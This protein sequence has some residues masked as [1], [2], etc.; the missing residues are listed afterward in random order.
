MPRSQA[1]WI[2]SAAVFSLYLAMGQNAFHGLDAFSYLK[3]VHNGELHNQLNLLY[4]P[5]AWVFARLCGFFGL[6]LYESLRLLSAIGGAL[7]AAFTHRTALALGIDPTRALLSAFGCG[8]TPAV[9]HSSTVVE[10]DA[11]FFACSA[12]AWLPFAHLLRTGRWSFAML[13]GAASALAAGCHAAGH[14]LVLTLCLMQIAWDWPARSL[15]TT[16]PRMFVLLITHAGLSLLLA[17]L[18]SVSGQ[19]T[20]ANNAMGITVRADFVP[21]VL[22]HEWLLPYMPFCL[23]PFVAL[24]VP[25]L[26][27]AVASFAICVLGYLLVTT[28]VL[29]L[30]EPTGPAL[31]HGGMFEFGSFLLG[32]TVPAVLLSMLALPVRAA[33]LAVAIA[34]VAGVLQVRA[35]D[36]PP[37]PIGYAAGFHELQQQAPLNV[38][39]DNAEERAWIARRHPDQQ[40]FTVRGNLELEVALIAKQKQLPFVPAT[41]ALQFQLWRPSIA[42]G[43]ELLVSERA[44]SRMQ[45]SP[46]PQLAEAARDLLPQSFTFEPVQAQGFRGYRLLPK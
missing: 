4:Q 2:A 17:K 15:R 5:L 31:P 38:L 24:R 9:L 21:H 40:C 46:V 37:D 28:I 14:L 19:A 45:S 7:G 35:H 34:C 18:A 20:M 10:I 33:V 16:V 3:F 29:G 43:K 23:L 39:V 27:T 32:S 13:T 36:W 11:L 1:T 26:R 25:R 41:F 8:L 30:L 22:W 12:L 44:L 6:P 42:G